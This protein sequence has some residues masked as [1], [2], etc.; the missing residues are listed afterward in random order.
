MLIHILAETASSNSGNS[1]ATVSYI[2]GILTAVGGFL[3]AAWKI[4]QNQ[5]KKWQSEAIQRTEQ[6][7]SIKE[8]SRRLDENSRSNQLLGESIAALG[9]KMDRFV[10]KVEVELNGHSKRLDALERFMPRGHGNGSD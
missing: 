1:L 3:A 5:K 9:T 4:N 6:E 10:D 8:N 2:I 7:A